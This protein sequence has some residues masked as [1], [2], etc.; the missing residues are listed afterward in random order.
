LEYKW[1]YRKG[2][3]CGVHRRDVRR[4]LRRDA[5]VLRGVGGLCLFRRRGSWRAAACRALERVHLA[6]GPR[7]GLGRVELGLLLSRG[8]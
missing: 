8:L 6:A 4:L 1:V 3:A 5:D 7:A 2:E